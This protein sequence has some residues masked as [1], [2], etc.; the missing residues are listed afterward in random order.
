MK[1]YPQSLQLGF[2][3]AALA[4]AGCGGSGGSSE[5][6]AAADQP[7]PPAPPANQTATQPSKT[8][9]TPAPAPA[10]PSAAPTPAPAVSP[11]GP[12]LNSSGLNVLNYNGMTIP[13]DGSVSYK[14][15]RDSGNTLADVRY[16]IIGTDAHQI[17]FVHG[18]P[19]D[20]FP[21]T[22]AAMYGGA[23]YNQFKATGAIQP[24]SVVTAVDFGLKKVRV[25]V[26][27][28]PT[29]NHMKAYALSF[30]GP[31]NGATFA[32]PL[33][34]A[35]DADRSLTQEG[36]AYGAFFGS[37]AKYMGGNYETPELRGVYAAE[38]PDD[39]GL[40]PSGSIPFD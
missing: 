5:N 38:R 19:V 23:G 12:I 24:A 8:G 35:H 16:G 25:A 18:K 17:M 10:A 30:E 39:P 21:A 15:F 27:A 14:D 26:A 29:D 31:F 32:I 36:T 33:K 9:T 3:I 28:I 2:V 22:G 20:N 7:A 40:I 11:V 13:L 34:D 6:A 4:L 37:N 1:K